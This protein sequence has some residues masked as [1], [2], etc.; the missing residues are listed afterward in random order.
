MF[1]SI[2]V[3]LRRRLVEVIVLLFNYLVCLLFLYVFLIYGVKLPK[4]VILLTELY[5]HIFII[6]ELNLFWGVSPWFL[7]EVEERFKNEL[8]YC[9]F[10]FLFIKFCMFEYID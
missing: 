3:V 5:K 7:L 6:N 2:C 1:C 10:N 9:F 8:S 4:K